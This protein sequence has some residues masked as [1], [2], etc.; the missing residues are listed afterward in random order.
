MPEDSNWKTP[1]DSPRASISYVGAVV[2]R[3]RADVDPPDEVD[4][5]VD[6]VEVAEAEEVHLQE[7]HVDD[8]VHRELGDDLLV[9]A[10]LLERDDLDERL[11]ADDDAGRVDRVGP[12][13]PLERAGELDDLLR[14]RVGLDRLR[15]LA[16]AL[17][18]LLERL[19]GPFRDH[20]REAVDDA[21]RDVEHAPGV[22]DRGARRH[23]REGDD[24]R[25]AVAAVLLG[26]VVDDAIAPGDGEVDVHVRQVLARRVEEAL[27]EEPVPASGRRR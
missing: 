2:E 3:Q 25:D 8:V 17:E 6:H 12:G 5:L 9:G 13:Q 19:A 14:D 1:I 21:V 22:A 27:E 7:P 4:R 26:D 23:R 15:E 16:P 18:R 11:R 24:L 10:L 20:L